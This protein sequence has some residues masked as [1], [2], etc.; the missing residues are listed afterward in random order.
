MKQ[1][2]QFSKYFVPT[3]ILSLVLIA[4]GGVGYFTK[5][6]N[7]GVDF[8]AGLIQEIQFAPTVFRLTYKGPGNA[9]ISFGR[10]SL[11]IVISGAGVDEVTHSFD[12]ASYPTQADIAKGLRGIEGLGVTEDTASNIRSSWLIQSA[13]SS[14]RLEPNNPFK[15]HYLP[16]DAADSGL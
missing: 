10:N 1:I 9:I 16:P 13:Q 12:Y 5:G 8:Q 7:L 15:V 11:D 4:F 2:I 3:V 6:F 14:P